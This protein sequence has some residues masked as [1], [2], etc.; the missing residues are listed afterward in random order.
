M[1]KEF[2]K[3]NLSITDN[4][5]ISKEPE[6]LDPM[7]EDPNRFRKLSEALGRTSTA[8]VPELHGLYDGFNR[9]GVAVEGLTGIHA[10]IATMQQQPRR[11]AEC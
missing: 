6:A 7:P 3:G 8:A 9:G 2:L 4:A 1:P 5:T 10:A 11:C